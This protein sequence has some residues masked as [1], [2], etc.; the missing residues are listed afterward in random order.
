MYDGTLQI[1]NNL[2]E[3]QIRPIPL[4]RKNFL[5]AGS[6]EGAR[7][8]A[9][10]YTFMAQCK[11]NAINPHQWLKNVFENILDTKPSQYHTLLPQNFVLQ[12]SSLANT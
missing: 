5:F 6:H 12:K 11:K 9:V 4:G 10:M 2:V 7:R 3:N 1:D 8:A